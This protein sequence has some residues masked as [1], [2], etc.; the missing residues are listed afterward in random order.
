MSACAHFMLVTVRGG[1][2]GQMRAETQRF[3]VSETRN[4][5]VMWF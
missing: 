5:A 4:D 1:L 3:S 2:I